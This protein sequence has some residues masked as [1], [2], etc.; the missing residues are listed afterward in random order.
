MT[1][2]P[3]T[4]HDR[5]MMAR[6]TASTTASTPASDPARGATASTSAS[7]LTPDLDPGI[8]VVDRAHR[9]L[10]IDAPWS[11]RHG[12]GFTHRTDGL[13]Q[14]VWSEPA[15]KD[16]GASAA[17]QR[18]WSEL[19]PT[20][21]PGPAVQIDRAIAEI[22]LV[23][24]VQDLGLA[25]ELANALNAMATMGAILVD[26]A[27]RS[28]VHRMS[29][30][31]TAGPATIERAGRWLA[32]AAGLQAAA[33]PALAELLANATGGTIAV[34]RHPGAVA[35]LGTER[36]VHMDRLAAI[37]GREP[38]RWT[39]T[40]LT[41]ARDRLAHGALRRLTATDATT[42]AMP[43]PV[44]GDMA[45][46]QALTHEP[47]PLLGSGLK[48]RLALPHGLTE[49]AGATIAAELNR[50]EAT[51]TSATHGIGAWIGSGGQL[52]HVAFLPNAAHTGDDDATE[53]LR[54]GLA[55]ARWASDVLA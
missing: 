27:R 7:R 1:T 32:V 48:M 16:A 9:V 45:Q 29:V 14:R 23:R 46:L 52:Q 36:T 49:T 41:I 17:P 51:P 33:S 39:G 26:P 18:A 25:T 24:D 6:P 54:S 20:T 43:I 40:A 44:A 13:V 31:A 4:V 34:P 15:S 42:F 19:S 53:L 37:A 5:G 47:H 11:L 8:A 38:S 55:R 21:Q 22:E 2:E 10:G 50:L 35:N 3:V 12:R 30:L 28:I